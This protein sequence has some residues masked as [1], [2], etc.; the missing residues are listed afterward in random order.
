MLAPIPVT[1]P[2]ASTVALLVLLLLQTPP[3]VAS[4]NCTLEFL[5]TQFVPLIAATVGNV[6][7]VILI[8]EE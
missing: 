8:V 5:Q 4:V 3:A 1:F 2:F 7:T 6:F